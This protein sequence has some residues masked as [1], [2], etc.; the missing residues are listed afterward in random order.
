MIRFLQLMGLPPT[1]QNQYIVP[2]NVGKE[3]TVI[4]STYKQVGNA[5]RV[6]ILFVYTSTQT[7]SFGV[8]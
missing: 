4:T 7:Q 3:Q 5:V 6:H 8:L 2:K 1:S